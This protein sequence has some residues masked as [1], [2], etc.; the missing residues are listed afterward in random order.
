MQ[1]VHGLQSYPPDA[2][3]AVVALGAFDGIHL[4]HRAI[5]GSAVARGKTR[6]ARV[7]ACTFDRHP[8]E[9]LQPARA[10]LPLTTLAERLE[11]IAETGVDVTLVLAFTR[12]FAAMEPEAFVKDVLVDRL[13]AREVVVGY[14]HTFGRGARGDAAL[15]CAIGTPVGLVTHVMPP[16]LVDGVPV[17]SSEIRAA[18]KDGDV[19]RAARYLGRPYSI[20]G[21]ITRGAGRG[22]TLGFPTANLEP[23]RVLLLPTGVY[24]CRADLEGA[25]HRAVVNVGV[26]PTFGE[27]TM[28]IE[29]HLLDM[30]ADVYGRRLRLHFVARLRGERK[31]P[32]VD[33]LRAQIA[34]DVAEA[35]RHL[36]TADFT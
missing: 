20:A 27:D 30:S 32:T 7:I 35:R 28:A 9:V 31:F 33:E 23:E 18:L 14:N 16:L 3:P 24:A 17:S 21:T 13:H 29:A 6:A 2:D 15:L 10:P 26:R 22:R 19:A 34:R 11:L 5:L 8:M 4:G 25:M 36:E 12:E 1:I